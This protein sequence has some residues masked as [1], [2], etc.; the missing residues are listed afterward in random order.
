MKKIILLVVLLLPA[1]PGIIAGIDT[2]RRT[3]EDRRAAELEKRF[4]SFCQAHGRD[5]YSMNNAERDSYYFD[6]YTETRDYLNAL[7]SIDSVITAERRAYI[8][9]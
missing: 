9:R 3:D 5:Y 4:I 8:L 7:D 6:V 2:D 1:V